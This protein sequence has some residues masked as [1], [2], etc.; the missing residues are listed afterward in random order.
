[1]YILVSIPNVLLT[2]PYSFVYIVSGAAF[3]LSQ[4]SRVIVT[5]TLWPAKLKICI[6]FRNT[7]R[8]SL[9]C[10]LYTSNPQTVPW[11]PIGASGKKEEFH[12]HLNMTNARLNKWNRFLCRTYQSIYF[13]SVH[14]ES[15]DRKY[16]LKEFQTHLATESFDF[17]FPRSPCGTF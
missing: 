6:I 10:L 9:W 3:M 15:L 11:R 17:F 12:S 7:N 4:Q 1:M 5:E 2:Q 13:A 8:K 16:C 14:Y